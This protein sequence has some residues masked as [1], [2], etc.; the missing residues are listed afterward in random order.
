MNREVPASLLPLFDRLCSDSVDV[1]DEVLLDSRGLMRSLQVDLARLLNTRN[2]LTIDQFLKAE[3]GVLQ[4]GLP[5]V[6]GLWPSS[7]HDRDRLADVIAHALASFEP[8]LSLVTIEVA[9]DPDSP[10]RARV[11]VAAA[12]RLG[13]QLRRVDF[14]LALDAR[15]G[16]AELLS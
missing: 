5:D 1:I 12:V 10:A 9:V 13:R 16:A 6:T 15:G 8:R 11:S 14:R 7:K 2:G 4:F 3:L